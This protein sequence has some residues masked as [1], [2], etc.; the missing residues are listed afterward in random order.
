MV[1][2]G[3]REGLAAWATRSALRHHR[4]QS[5]KVVWRA[6]EVS[7]LDGRRYGPVSQVSGK[8]KILIVGGYGTFGGRLVE[9]IENEPR[10]T[11]MIGGRSLDKARA[12][13][14]IRGAVKARLV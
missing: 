9:L 14:A 7:C 11:I 12:F 8:V 10:L 1:A 2:G 13:A 4:P 5:L 3:R 6:Q